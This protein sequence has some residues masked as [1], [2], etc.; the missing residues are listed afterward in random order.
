M[1]HRKLLLLALLVCVVAG[2]VLALAYAGMS[3]LRVGLGLA[4]VFVLPG[5]LFSAALFPKGTIDSVERLLFSLGISVSIIILGGLILNA[6]PWGLQ[7]GSWLVLLLIITVGSS[8]VVFAR[9]QHRLPALAMP[10]VRLSASQMILFG[11]ATIMVLAAINVARTPTPA[12]GTEGYTQLWMLP[13]GASGQGSIQ[14]GIKSF[15]LTLVRYKL[16]L[17]AGDKPLYEWPSIELEPG[18]EWSQTKTL[19]P[20]QRGTGSVRALLFRLD[21]LDWPPYRLVELT[22]E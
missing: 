20:E 7:L 16:Q 1:N 2:V 19:L 21:D 9:Q 22:S 3:F 11:A 6:T 18:Q 17:F 13:N 10:A 4:L 5:Y 14:F 12:Q 15:E 8:L